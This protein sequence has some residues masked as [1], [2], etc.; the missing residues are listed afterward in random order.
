MKDIFEEQLKNLPKAKPT[1]YNI[2]DTYTNHFVDEEDFCNKR[3]ERYVSKTKTK[4]LEVMRD[5]FPTMFEKDFNGREYGLLKVEDF[6]DL[7]FNAIVLY[8]FNEKNYFSPGI[9]MNEYCFEHYSND[10]MEGSVFR[11]II[12]TIPFN[13]VPIDELPASE[14]PKT[15][16]DGMIVCSHSF[17][18]QEIYCACGDY[19]RNKSMFMP[20]IT[21][22][23]YFL[24]LP[25]TVEDV[26]LI[27]RDVINRVEIDLER[28]ALSSNENDVKTHFNYMEEKV[29]SNLTTE[30][31]EKNVEIE[32][33]K[34]EI[35]EKDIQ[36][37]N[38]QK[39]IE[40][41]EKS[42]KDCII[43]TAEY[44]EALLRENK[45][46]KTK[47][48]ILL[49]KYNEI[50]ELFDVE[51]KRTKEEQE[52]G[53]PDLDYSENYGFVVGENAP[54]KSIIKEKFPNC[55]FY[56]KNENISN[57]TKM[58]V[59]ITSFIGH[60][61]YYA[62]KEQCKNKNIPIVHCAHS[63]IDLMTQLMKNE[64]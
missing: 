2:V 59:F 31:S 13:K 40:N 39:K 51:N 53:L 7:V 49:N 45:K 42:K 48:E 62:L 32:K 25:E 38:T 55:T 43:E 10:K 3:F 52:F 44:N 6:G 22:E 15:P 12:C 60:P 33:L 29:F 9:F 46:I 23:N 24:T 57:D 58:V 41:I 34:K 14:R 18:E 20:E 21:K 35:E 47:Y 26:I 63:N 8:H 16:E 28:F 17:A 27:F 36:L 64:L 1:P 54:Y 37:K 50:K 56:S 61:T 30:I 4:I 5:V 19:I 11:N